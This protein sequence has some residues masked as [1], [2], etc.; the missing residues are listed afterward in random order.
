MP[1]PHALPLMTRVT[2]CV[3]LVA[4]LP[5]RA[6]AAQE[7]P[8]RRLVQ[9]SPCSEAQR[10]AGCLIVLGSGTPVPEPDRA[11]PAYA[12]LYRDR[13][14]LFDAGAGIMRRVAAAGLRINGVT[15]A[16]L[17][18][19]HSD[20]TIGLPDLMFTTWVMGRRGPFP[21]IGPPGTQAMV[22]HLM[23]AYAED[24]KVRVTGLER[25]QPSGPGVTVHES[26][27][28]V[29]LDSAG[30]RITAIPVPHSEFAM[31]FGYLIELPTRR[32]VLSGDTGPSLAIEAA[33]KGADLLI[34]E[35]YPAVRL[36]P[37][38]RPGG[39]EWPAYMR[40]VHTSDAEVG[41][42]A[43]RAGVKLVVLSHVVWM[44]GT[45]QEVLDGVRRAG[46][47]GAIRV[48][49]DLEAY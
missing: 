4:L 22:D 29:V 31:N 34:H 36:K 8:P 35:S 25:G 37:E 39:E 1:L 20:H 41:A 33:A 23:M 43:E 19:L 49:R 15:A 27:G 14:F 11:G 30:V 6:L 2:L 5:L 32:I 16:F 42:M 44:G 13:L 21:L 3:S 24:T 40:K 48:A 45:E 12:L 28:G 46:Y 38:D 10:A 17:T 7:A 18:H 26:T 47:R 9:Q